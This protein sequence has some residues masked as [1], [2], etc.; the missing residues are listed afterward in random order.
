[1]AHLFQTRI[2]RLATLAMVPRTWRLAIFALAGAAAGLAALG[3]HLSRAPSYLSDSPETCMNCH[4]MGAAYLTWQHSSHGRVTVCTDCHVPHDNLAHKLWFK[5]QDGL[6]HATV[7]TL[8]S[9]PQVMSLN[10]VA[11]PVVEA[12]CRRC[13]AAVVGDIHARAWKP[14]DPRCWDC[15][16]EVPHGIGRSLSSTPQELRPV[17]PAPTADPR[18]MTIHGRTVRP[19]GSAT[20]APE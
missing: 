20:D 16:R 9:E 15:H 11:V 13:H 1:M 10:P 17:L 5:A 7:F 19:S 18:T 8:R 3:L 2:G 14:G 12:N 4:V 6:R